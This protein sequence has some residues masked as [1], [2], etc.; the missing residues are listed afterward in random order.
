VRAERCARKQALGRLATRTVVS[1]DGQALHSLLVSIHFLPDGGSRPTQTSSDLP[2]RVVR[3]EA[4]RNLLAP[5][6]TQAT[7]G[8]TIRRP[9]GAPHGSGIEMMDPSADPTG[10]AIIVRETP[11][12][13]YPKFAVACPK[14][15][16][17]GQSFPCDASK[18]G[19][20]VTDRLSLPYWPRYL[21]AQTF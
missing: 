10:L 8:P 18:G 2:G 1:V 13:T 14:V 7:G 20:K 17:D 11:A 9:I 5:G 12:C 21:V 3:R 4:T 16:P 6:N 19:T 15:A